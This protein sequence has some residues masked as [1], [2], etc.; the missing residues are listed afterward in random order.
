VRVARPSERV[1]EI[2]P[3]IDAPFTKE[4]GEVV[5]PRR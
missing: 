1:L 4:D 3:P 5:P 2:L